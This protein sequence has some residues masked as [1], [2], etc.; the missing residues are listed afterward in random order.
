MQ[1]LRENGKSLSDH[2]VPQIRAGV[3][4]GCFKLPALPRG[5]WPSWK[6]ARTAQRRGSE[7]DPGAPHRSGVHWAQPVAVPGLQER[8]RCRGFPVSAGLVGGNIGAA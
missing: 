4:L 2:A 6:A 1:L 3:S 7:A 8:G 5:V